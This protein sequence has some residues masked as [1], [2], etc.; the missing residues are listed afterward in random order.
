MVFY[1]VRKIKGNYYLYKVEYD[2]Y[3]GKRQKVIGNCET[4]E[5]ILKNQ[6]TKYKKRRRAAV[7]QPWLERRPGKATSSLD[8][9]SKGYNPSLP[10]PSDELVVKFY[11]WCLQRNSE[12]TCKDRANYLKKPLDPDNNH[13][14]KAYRLF[15]RFLGIEPPRELKVKQSGIDLK[16]PSDTEIIESIRKACSYNAKL[17]LVYRILIE[18]GARLEEV[19]DMLRNYDIARNKHHNGFLVY[20]LNRQSGT[21]K[22]FYIFHV[23][24][25]KPVNTN[26]DWVGKK[27]RELGIV[28]AK[29]IRKW[30]AT[31]LASLGF[32]SSI[33]DFIQGRTPRSILSKHYLN[34]YALATKEYKKYVEWLRGMGLV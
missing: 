2:P 17:C 9:Q 28:R 31:K 32:D 4:I 6:D 12:R 7:A 11:N 5:A 27:A 22:S 33:I 15:Y 19:L 16:V 26:K 34:L 23:T 25:A 10:P 8:N 18:S 14:V 30:V 3:L 20:E 13:S 1:F 21:K 24:P 29:Y